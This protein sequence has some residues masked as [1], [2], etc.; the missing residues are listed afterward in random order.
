MKSLEGKQPVDIKADLHNKAT[1]IFDFKNELFDYSIRFDYKFTFISILFS[2]FVCFSSPSSPLFVGMRLPWKGKNQA[3]TA[4]LVRKLKPLQPRCFQ[5]RKKLVYFVWNHVELKKSNRKLFLHWQIWEL[6]LDSNRIRK[7]DYEAFSLPFI[8][9]ITLDYN[10]LEYIDFEELAKLSY[11]E[12]F[13]AKK[14]TSNI[15]Y[16]SFSM[17]TNLK[18]LNLEMCGIFD[19]TEL[20]TLLQSLKK[21]QSLSLKNLLESITFRSFS[22]EWTIWPSTIVHCEILATIFKTI[23]HSTSF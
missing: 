15:K 6:S 10:S 7:I 4:A 3:I 18:N 19:G 13:S 1:D 23:M 22:H 2:A 21:C 12:S 14:T 16:S 9:S 5:S 8:R 11:L 17:M 20:L